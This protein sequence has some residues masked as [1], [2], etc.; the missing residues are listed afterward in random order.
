MYME[1]TCSEFASS[2]TSPFLTFLQWVVL[3][4]LVH[5]HCTWRLMVFYKENTYL[6]MCGIFLYGDSFSNASSP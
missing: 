1:E 5:G 3:S 6:K 4:L 2:S